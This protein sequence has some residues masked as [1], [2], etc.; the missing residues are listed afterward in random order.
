MT[1]LS[2][3]SPCTYLDEDGSL[4]LVSVGWLSRVHP[5]PVGPIPAA[6]RS[7]LVSLMREPSSLTDGFLGSHLSEFCAP[8]TAHPHDLSYPHGS[9][10]LV[11]PGDTQIYAC[12]SL[13]VHYIGTHGYQPPYPF[14]SPLYFLRLLEIG[15]SAWRRRV[16]RVASESSIWRDDPSGS[17]I[18][19]ALA[20]K[21]RVFS[22]NAHHALHQWR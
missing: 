13:I 12:P 7:Q 21:M 3:L 9:A 18:E 19:P 15:G 16:E 11:V 10:N 8:P 20:E 17:P 4:G 5:F 22:S 2:D 14:G 1:Y 6:F